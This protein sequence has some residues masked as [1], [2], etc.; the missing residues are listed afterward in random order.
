MYVRERERESEKHT[1]HHCIFDQSTCLYTPTHSRPVTLPKPCKPAHLQLRLLSLLPLPLS[2]LQHLLRL[3][4]QLLPR[5]HCCVCKYAAL[6]QRAL[7]LARLPPQ[8]GLCDVLSWAA[9][10]QAVTL[11]GTS[12]TALGTHITPGPWGGVASQGIASTCGNVCDKLF[13][14]CCCVTVT[15]FTTNCSCLCAE[16]GAGTTR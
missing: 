10:L 12:K 6:H 3:L 1:T 9:V 14:I 5:L 15:V 2:S 7:T 13:V 16:G 11:Q 4:L 8:V